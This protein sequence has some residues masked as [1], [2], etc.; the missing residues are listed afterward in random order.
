MVRGGTFVFTKLQR[1]FTKRFTR[2]LKKVRSLSTYSQI[3]DT[4]STGSN[5]QRLS[6]NRAVLRMF[7][8]RAKFR[9]IQL[10][11]QRIS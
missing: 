8:A 9:L 10:Y 4:L 5:L 1:H 2:V 7:G 6:R 3:Y 11:F